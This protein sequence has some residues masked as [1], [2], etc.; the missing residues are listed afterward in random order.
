MWS[1]AFAF[2]SAVIWFAAAVVPIRRTVWVVARV[3]GGGPSPELDTVLRRLRLQS[4]LNAAA[5]L[6]MFIAALLQLYRR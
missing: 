2:L 3:G 5:A 1:I 6:S 4:W